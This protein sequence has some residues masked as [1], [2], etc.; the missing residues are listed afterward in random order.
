MKRKVKEKVSGEGSREGMRIMSW[1]E[2]GEWMGT[3]GD[4]KGKRLS[5]WEE[6]K[7]KGKGSE[8]KV[9]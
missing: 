5:E 7:V 1:V 2:K 9:K 6:D 8:W 4:G 3:E